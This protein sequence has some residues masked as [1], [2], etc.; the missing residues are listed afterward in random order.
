[1]LSSNDQESEL[2]YA[3]LHAVAASAGLSCNFT[4]RH[5]DN[6]GIDAQVIARSDKFDG[7]RARVQ[8]DIQLK[9]TILKPTKLYKGYL[10]YRFDKVDKYDKLREEN[11]QI[12]AF[13]VV[14]FL[15]KKNDAKKWLEVSAKE[16]KIRKAAYWVS[17]RGAKQ[18]E[19]SSGLTIYLPEVNLLTPSSL[20][21]IFNKTSKDEA[22][23]YTEPSK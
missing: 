11:L 19:N 12:P 21:D 23:N 7:P 6:L 10:G 3:Y 14:L 1:M 8:V 20:F 9:A 15:P 5:V 18:S 17:L 16:L 2:S 13:L 4:S 22:I